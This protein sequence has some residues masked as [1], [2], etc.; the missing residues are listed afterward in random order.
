M[1]QFDYLR[2]GGG[3]NQCLG[4]ESSQ[5]RGSIVGMFVGSSTTQADRSNHLF[6]GK[7]PDVETWYSGYSYGLMCGKL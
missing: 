6:V 3:S 7:K 5:G 2:E 1:D 4:P